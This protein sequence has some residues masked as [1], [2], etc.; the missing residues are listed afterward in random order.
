MS[1][2][3]KVRI[4]LLDENTGKPITEVDAI[5]SSETILYSNKNP[6]LADVGS[7]KKGTKF[8][9]TPLS[10][11]L[12]GVLYDYV[13]PTIKEIYLSSSITVEE[14]TNIVVQNNSVVESHEYSAVIESG[15]KDNIT[16]LFKIYKNDSTVYTKSIQLKVEPNK[17]YSIAFNVPE[18]DNDSTLELSLFDSLETVIS[19]LVKYTFTDPIFVGFADPELL[20]N[21]NL[22]E[23]NISTITE[24]F[25]GNIN[26]SVYI[27]ERLVTKSNQNHISLHLDYTKRKSLN[28]FILVPSYWGNPKSI[29]DTNGINITNSYTYLTEIYLDLYNDDAK[30]V[31]YIL[32]MSRGTFDVNADMLNDILYCFDS[33][34]ALE[35][36]CIGNGSPLLSS[37]SVQTNIPIDD[38][39]VVETYEDLLKTQRP[40][41]G[42][43]VYVKDIDTIFRYTTE[44]WLPTA[45][46]L[47]LVDTKEELNDSIGGW[48]DVVIIA[49]T[50][51][52]YRKRYNNVWEYWGTI[53][54]K[55]AVEME[56]S[57]EYRFNKSYEERATYQNTLRFA[58]LV[59]HN[60]STW[61]CVKT[62]SGIEPS[63]AN[64]EYWAYFAK[65][66]TTTIRWY[67]YET[68]REV[69]INGDE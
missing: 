25:R 51:N 58:D 38:R 60:G 59:Y 21:G 47:Y 67:D 17:T 35:Y 50:G 13:P 66:G 43:I 29:F 63:E 46:R 11:I 44:G 10:E 24:Y 37:F 19:P 18:I 31:P 15:T 61:Y 57:Q 32:Y 52:I 23:D 16:C 53:G 3:T 69:I 49:E 30:L 26:N 62:C 20:T 28:P 27:E 7:I 36:K 14:N 5:T 41:V 45:T 6:M 9:N 42:L 33:D 34:S 65:G 64:S 55:N 1:K 22:I 39:F 4:E 56:V 40:Y 12:D 8:D 68:N 2:L 54:V 48:D